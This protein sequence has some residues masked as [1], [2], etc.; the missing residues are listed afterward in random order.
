V[1]KSSVVTGTG[2]GEASLTSRRTHPD[3]GE[4]ALVGK[5]AL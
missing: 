1:G 3:L 2:E 4:Q 5:L